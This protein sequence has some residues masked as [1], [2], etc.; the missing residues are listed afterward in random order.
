MSKRKYQK[1][2]DQLVKAIEKAVDSMNIVMNKLKGYVDQGDKDD[3]K[4]EN[5]AVATKNA[6]DEF[7]FEKVAKI[8]SILDWKWAGG[9]DDG[10]FGVPSKDRL[11]RTA[12]RLIDSAWKE[13]DV[14]RCCKFDNQDGNYKE[15]TVGTG[16]FEIN[17]WEDDYESCVE[18]KFILTD[19]VGNSNDG[20]VDESCTGN[21]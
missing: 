21:G 4:F 3:E 11:V 13:L 10:T 6:I 2:T 15:M 1:D 7:D 17:V 9:A 16:G 18:I 5:R 20:E 12:R 14:S 8:M 19:S